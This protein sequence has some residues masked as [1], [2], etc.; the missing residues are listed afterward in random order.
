MIAEG[1]HA[2][3]IRVIGEVTCNGCCSWESLGSVIMGSVLM[4]LDK[5]NFPRGYIGL[6]LSTGT[7]MLYEFEDGSLI[8][9]GNP[10]A[11]MLGFML[12]TR[13]NKAGTLFEDQ[14]KLQRALYK[15][16]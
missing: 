12:N 13:K 10:E 2:R 15:M 7:P 16:R 8:Q 1:V 5:A 14:M 4:Y 3:R 6:E 11:P 9:K